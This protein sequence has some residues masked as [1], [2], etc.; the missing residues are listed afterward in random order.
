MRG[1][2]LAAH[3]PVV[4]STTFYSKRWN[5]YNWCHHPTLPSPPPPP[6]PSPSP[7]PAAGSYHLFLVCTGKV[8][9][10]TKLRYE[11]SV[12]QTT[13]GWFRPL[14]PVQTT[15]TWSIPSFFRL[16]RLGLDIF[17]IWLAK[18]AKVG[19]LGGVRDPSV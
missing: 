4:H 11:P 10:T 17:N 19:P 18:G 2:K 13:L 6:P 7:P 14:F 15:K 9:Q 1:V 12:V 3:K 5:G 16:L 8:V